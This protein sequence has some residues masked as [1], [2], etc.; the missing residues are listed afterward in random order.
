M[1]NRLSVT[2]K[3]IAMLILLVVFITAA[4]TLAIFL[5]GQ[6]N[7]MK[8]VGKNTSTARPSSPTLPGTATPTLPKAMTATPAA[9]PAELYVLTDDSATK[10]LQEQAVQAG[11]DAPLTVQSVTFTQEQVS[12]TGELN[13]MGYQGTLNIS[14]VP[15]VESKKL[16]FQLTEVTL[17]GKGLPSALFPTIEEQINALFDQLLADVDVQGVKLGEGEM[18]L[19]VLRH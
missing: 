15:R 2:F 14:G 16:R 5:L 4:F 12:L 11:A 9:S 3:Q 6:Q 8:L 19:T 13:A 17:D 7:G 10:I 18:S 1:E